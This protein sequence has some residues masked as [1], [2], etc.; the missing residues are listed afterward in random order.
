MFKTKVFDWLTDG[1][2]K[3]FRSPTEGNFI[4]RLLKTSL[5]PEVK[6][7]RLLHNFSCNAYEVA[8]YTGANLI[9]FRFLPKIT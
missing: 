8:D 2:I 3:L 4:V 1:N 9:N 5:S 7:G 6:L